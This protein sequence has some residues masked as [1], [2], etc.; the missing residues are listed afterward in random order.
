MIESSD[1]AL[2]AARSTTHSNLNT[3]L[4]TQIGLN[5]DNTV[6][7]DEQKQEKVSESIPSH[8]KEHKEVI[9][10]TT[11]LPMI[12]VEIQMVDTGA[13]VTI[14]VLLDS[15]ATT[16]FIDENFAKENNL[17]LIPLACTIPVYNVDGTL[18]KEGSIRS[19]INMIV[20]VQEHTEHTRFHVA[21]LGKI[22]VILGKLWL[23]THNPEINWIS[24]TVHFTHCPQ[25]CHLQVV[26]ERKAYREKQKPYNV[27][28]ERQEA[29][30]E[31]RILMV[32]I[33]PEEEASSIHNISQNLAMEAEKKKLK[34]Y[35]EEIVPN[36]YHHFKQ[37][38]AKE[39]F[40][41]L[42]PK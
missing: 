7:S 28:I 6:I 37:V 17:I 8:K 31:D 41:E 32:M 33:G 40:D 14:E 20:R 10:A 13:K 16:C 30:D 24:G 9:G 3:T 27:P 12:Q 4:F 1:I 23:K 29:E 11:G 38:F 2:N 26:Q 42:P 22:N 18:N 25:R 5:A 36:T 35:F 15:G 21:G 34:K 39:S 19:T